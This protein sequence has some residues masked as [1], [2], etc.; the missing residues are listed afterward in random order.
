MRAAA[1]LVEVGPPLRI[2]TLG[3]ARYASYKPSMK[4][5]FPPDMIVC[6]CVI[7]PQHTA[8]ARRIG[9]RTPGICSRV[10]NHPASVD[11]RSHDPTRP[12]PERAT[13]TV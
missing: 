4:A 9:T 2:D 8:P 5:A 10:R 3:S 12:G 1:Q 13:M 6:D 7:T 11:T